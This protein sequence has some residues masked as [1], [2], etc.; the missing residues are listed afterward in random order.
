MAVFLERAMAWP[1]A[2]IIP[3][4]SGTIFDDVPA[5]HWAAAWIE[6]LAADGITGGCSS[7]PPLYCPD[8]P[9]TREQMAVFLVRSFELPI[10]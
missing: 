3:P 4:A 5:D 7:V 9:V 8:N 1:D 10:E 6:Q 2:T